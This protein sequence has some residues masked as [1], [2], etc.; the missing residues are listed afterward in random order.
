VLLGDIPL[1]ASPLSINTKP[2]GE[3]MVKIS[4][5]WPRRSPESAQRRRRGRPTSSSA[6]RWP[7]TSK[8]TAYREYMAMHIGTPCVFS[9]SEQKASREKLWTPSLFKKTCD[10][11]AIGGNPRSAVGRP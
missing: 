6:S 1:M 5:P 9:D 10:H 4:R 8:R 3:K 2:M 11:C 7:P